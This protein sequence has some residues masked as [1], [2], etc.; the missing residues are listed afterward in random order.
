MTRGKLLA[1]RVAL[2]LALTV[3]LCRAD[4]VKLKP[5]FN[6]FSKEQDVQLGREAAAQVAQQLPIVRD[7]EIVRYVQEIG[8]KLSSQPKAENYPYSFQVVNDTA[9]NAFALPGGPTFVNTGLIRAA[10]NEAQIAGVMAHEIAHV[11]LRHGTNQASKANL[12]Q[13]PAMIAGSIAGGGGSL[14]G[15]LAQMG[16]GL[17][18]NSVLMKFSRSAEREA[19]L[20]GTQLMAGAGYD[21]LQL[22]RFF[23]KLEAQGGRG[24]PEFLSSHPNPGNRRQAIE[25]EVRTLSRRTYTTN[26]PQFQRA[27]QLVAS[28]PPAARGANIGSADRSVGDTRPT[29]ALKEYRGRA[30]SISYPGNWEAFGEPDSGMVTLAPRQGIVQARDGSSAIAVGAVLSFFVPRYNDGNVDLERETRDLIAQLQSSNPTMRAAANPRR[31]KVG[32]RNGLS[33]TLSSASPLGG[34]EVD[35]LVTA[36][37]PEGLFYC[38]LIAPRSDFDQVRGAFDQMIASIRFPR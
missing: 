29:G 14:L 16:I 17:G 28:I 36:A 37:R 31:V 13:L 8:R 21:P 24:G 15:Q 35:L 30:F 34:D 3:P 7:Q 20:L 1:Y 26:S 5:G 4:H 25:E 10:E 23:E 18:A 27:Q 2:A 11:A 19:D 33:T 6:M 12:L 32:G 9:I 22:A 38:V